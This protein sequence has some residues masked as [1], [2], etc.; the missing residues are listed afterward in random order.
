VEAI[1]R[2]PLTC[3]GPTFLGQSN[4]CSGP[5]HHWD[6]LATELGGDNHLV[7]K[8]SQRFA[9]EG[10]GGGGVLRLGRDIASAGSKN[11]TPRRTA[12]GSNEIIYFG[13]LTG[14]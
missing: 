13:R 9:H 8:W 14:P 6:R 7:T 2:R 12:V 3:Y 5:V 4:A 1:A 11:V 10:G